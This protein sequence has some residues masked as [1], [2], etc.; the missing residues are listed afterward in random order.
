MAS[1]TLEHL[2]TLA[3]G[4][5]HGVPPTRRMLVIVNPYASTVSDRLKHLVVYAL[6]GRYDVE[7]VDTQSP[8]HAV[9]L[10]R[11]AARDGV[12]VVV[13]FG[14]DGTVNEVANG[15][16]GTDTALSCLPGGSNN[17]FHR[18]LG[19]PADIVERDRAS[20]APWPGACCC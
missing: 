4:S 18:L 5:E 8:E 7:A 14:G 6:R 13:A 9:D 17:V 15:L 12:D 2:E 1:T 3:S 16:A 20:P 11:D 10:S 19:I